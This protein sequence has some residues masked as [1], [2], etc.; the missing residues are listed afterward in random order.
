M[1]LGRYLPQQRVEP[2]GVKERW[3]RIRSGDTKSDKFNPNKTPEPKD[4][5]QVYK[6]SVPDHP[7][8]PRHWWGRNANGDFDRFHY[9]N[10]GSAHYSGTFGAR[11]PQIPPYVLSRLGY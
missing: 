6:T 2:K 8:S 1:Q 4:C 11:A 5:P 10:D 3:E 7:S 9:T